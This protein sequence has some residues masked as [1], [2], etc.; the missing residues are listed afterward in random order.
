MN[1]KEALRRIKPYKDQENPKLKKWDYLDEPYKGVIT[2]VYCKFCGDT[3]KRMKKIQIGT[4]K[5]VGVLI[6]LANYEEVLFVFDDGSAHSTPMCKTCFKR[7]KED[8]YEGLYL[9][10]LDKMA[11]HEAK[12]QG[13]VNWHLVATRKPLKHLRSR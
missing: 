12:G 1:R 3:I 5:D 11:E 10:D 4:L 8:D 2:A 9:A 13:D 6:E 7:L